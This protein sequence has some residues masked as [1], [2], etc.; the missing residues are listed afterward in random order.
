MR[1]GTTS[2]NYYCSQHPEIYTPEEK[3]T[4]FFE[5]DERYCKGLEEYFKFFAG[6]NGE[7]KVASFVG[8]PYKEEV[9]HRIEYDLGSVQF[10]FI[11]RNPVEW[12][13]S[14]YYFGMSKGI[15]DVSRISFGEF[16]RSSDHKWADTIMNHAKH[17]NYLRRYEERFGSE[18]MMCILL[19]DLREHPHET[20]SDVYDFVG[21][22][23][24][25]SPN[26]EAQNPTHNVRFPKTHQ[27]IQVLWAPMKDALPAGALSSARSL[28]K[29]MFFSENAKRPDMSTADRAY[30]NRYYNEHNRRLEQWLERDLSHWT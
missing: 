16:I 13:H 30:L 5:E 11:L 4:S 20:M 12:V 8:R 22:D 21:V 29:N 23:N 26:M 25:F 7:D 19:S 3:E 6:Y 28:V 15:F 17:F 27:I 24:S 18:S 10:V 1:S 14:M 2:L 9:P